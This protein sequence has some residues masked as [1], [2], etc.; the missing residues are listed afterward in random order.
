MAFPLYDLPGIGRHLVVRVSGLYLAK[1]DL[2]ALVDIVREHVVQRARH[3]LRSNPDM[4]IPAIMVDFP[5][6][7]F[8]LRT[9]R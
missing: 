4:D 5:V 8:L 7:L 3:L 6:S 1:L 2:D 9:L